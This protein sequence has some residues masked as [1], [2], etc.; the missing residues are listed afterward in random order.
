MAPRPFAFAQGYKREFR[1][2]RPVPQHHLTLIK[3]SEYNGARPAN[4]S[5][6][7]LRMTAGLEGAQ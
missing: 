1:K 5:F 2:P 7:R 6:G 3:G 4:L